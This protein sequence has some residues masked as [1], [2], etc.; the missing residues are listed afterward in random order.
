MTTSA[1]SRR[2]L[3]R[4]RPPPNGATGAAPR[5]IRYSPL[6]P[7]QSQQRRDARPPAWT[8]DTGEPGALQTQPVVVDGVLY[9]Y[10]SS[11]KL[12]ALNAATGARL[13]MFDPGVPS[14]GP[15][16][17]VMYWRGGGETRVFAAAADFIW[18][19]D[20]K[21]GQPIPTFGT[22]GRIDLRE[23]LG[24]APETQSVRLTTPGVVYRDLMI[25]GGRVSEGLPA[26]PG[27]IRAYDVRTGAL[28]WTF[29][30]VPRPGEFGLR[31]VAERRVDV[32]RR[33]EQLAGHGARRGARRRV[34]ADRIGGIGLLRR[35]SARRQPVCELARR[36]RRIHGQAALALSVRPARRVGSRPA[37]AAEPDDVA[38]ERPDDRGRRTVHEARLCLRVRSHE[39]PAGVPDRVPAVSVEHGAW[40]GHARD[41]ADS[42]EAGAVRSSAADREPAVHAHARDSRL[43]A[44]ASSRRSRAPGSS[45]RSA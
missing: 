38:A 3:R 27:D 37:V 12:F 39:R 29:H 45:C 19:L 23:H 9:G 31:D 36:A 40:R 25:V 5:Q 26:S 43:G 33:R 6:D 10:T 16:R 41:A 44:R 42:D 22:D 13:W 35:G 8:Y 11:H 7:D 24:R 1:L 2:R 28:R 4:R 15:N 18:A 32:H 14:G 20:A 34:R 21:T 30:T 17:G